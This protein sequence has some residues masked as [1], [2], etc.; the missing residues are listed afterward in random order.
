MF[1]SAQCVPL[2]THGM[3]Q[4]NCQTQL[5]YT[6]ASMSGV[7]T[8]TAVVMLPANP[9]SQYVFHVIHLASIRTLHCSPDLCK[10]GRE[11]PKTKVWQPSRGT[12]I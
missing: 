8:A 5:S 1:T 9:L 7:S 11:W 10:N 2:W 3:A 12:V 4:C 6:F